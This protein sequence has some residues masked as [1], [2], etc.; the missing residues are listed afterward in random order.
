[1]FGD[2][3]SRVRLNDDAFERLVKVTEEVRRSLGSEIGP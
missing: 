2:M 1:M 3:G